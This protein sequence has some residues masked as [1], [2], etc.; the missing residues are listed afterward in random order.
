MADRITHAG[1]VS[2]IEHPLPVE[3]AHVIRLLKQAGAIIHVRTN[4]PQSLM[5]CSTQPLD[6]IL[7]KGLHIAP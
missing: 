2:F 4:Q 6:V 7:L 5:V 1:F 3:D